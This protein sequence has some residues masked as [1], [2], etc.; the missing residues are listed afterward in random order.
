MAN[1]IE[2]L[3]EFGSIEWFRQPDPISVQYHSAQRA[4]PPVIVWRYSDR[5]PELA[6]KLAE[7]I[8]SF[9]GSV[10]WS[11]DSTK[12]NWVVAPSRARNYNDAAKLQETEPEYDTKAND[13][14]PQLADHIRHFM[15]S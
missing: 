8:A 5:N 11:F 1:I 7:A 10:E 3:A 12:R 4:Y 9:K 6:A 2:V 14:L 15:M 13:E